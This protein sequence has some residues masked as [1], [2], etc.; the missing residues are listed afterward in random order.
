[1][2]RLIQTLRLAVQRKLPAHHQSILSGLVVVVA[3]IAAAKALGALKEMS[4]AWRF[5][6]GAEIDAYMLVFTFMNWPT[7]IWLSVLPSLV[8]PI[9]AKIRAT[10]PREL[11]R[12]RG[13]LLRMSILIGI[14]LTAVYLAVLPWCF[15]H[16]FFGLP[17]HTGKLAAS[18]MRVMGWA[19]LPGFLGALYAAWTM[20]GGRHANTLLEGVPALVVMAAV[21]STAGVGSLAWGT[22]VGVVAQAV[23]L[24]GFVGRVKPVGGAERS[25]G[26]RQFW[27]ALRIALVGQVVM[28]LTSLVDQ[29]F[30]AGLT[31]GSISSLGYS[32]RVLGLLVGLGATA[33]GR[34]TLPVFS[35]AGAGGA[36]DVR[37]A[38][39]KW[40]LVMALCGAT[41]AILGWFV[42]PWL[43]RV[44]F[45]R[46]TF[47]PDDALVVSRLLRLGLLQIPP[48]FASLVLVSMH[49]ALG[50]YA[51]LSG[52][53]F[54][55]LAVKLV[56]GSILVKYFGV[57]G[58]V[59]S[60][61][62]VY[63]CNSVLLL[64]GG[65]RAAASHR[66]DGP[67]HI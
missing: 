56:F 20:S 65:R 7:S 62:I 33:V 31:E 6:V 38:A 63:L 39:M 5:G 53:G 27:P 36:V 26:W 55:G 49:S 35:E 17:L 29:A 9:E 12:F 44:L 54:L 19:V 67:G 8:I 21:L 28:S 46:G 60:Q 14:A 50:N 43:V 16:G 25:Q 22:L 15:T 10:S 32:S 40:S 30:A 51:L 13:E 41:V 3:F 61:A 2:R 37:R 23:C 57:E 4:L 24:I 59:I 18:M 48:Y 1:M 47:S 45:V 42:A 52:S 66:H 34:A 11:P 58:L 64:V